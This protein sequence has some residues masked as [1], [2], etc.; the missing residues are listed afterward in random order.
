MARQVIDTR[1]QPS[2][3]VL[4]GIL[5]RGERHLAGCTLAVPQGDGRGGV[6]PRLLEA[7]V[8][9]PRLRPQQKRAFVR[10]EHAD[11]QGR[12]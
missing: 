7:P 3:L 9:Q 12:D 6:V 11:D 4:H 10:G 2:F 8:V 1:F 5:W